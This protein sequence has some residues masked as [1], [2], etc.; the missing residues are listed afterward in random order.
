M[1][2]SPNSADCNQSGI[3]FPFLQGNAEF[4]EKYPIAKNWC[5]IPNKKSEKDDVLLS[6]RAPIGALNIA[7]Q[8]YGIGRG[9]CAVRAEV[10]NYIYYLLAAANNELLSLGTGSTFTAISAEQ[11]GNLPIPETSFAAQTHIA[12]YLDRKTAEIDILIARKERLIEL[13]EE[14]KTAVINQAVTKGLDPDVTMKPSGI[15]W[16]GDIPEHW[17]V[18]RLGHLSKV[19]RGASPRPA[20]SPVYFNGNHTPWITVGEITKDEEKYLFSTSDYLTEAGQ[21]QSRYIEKG[22]LLLSNSGAT[23]GVPKITKIGGC[24]NDGSVAFFNIENNVNIDFIYYFLKSLTLHLRE[25]VKVSGQPNLNTDIVKSIMVSISDDNEQT[26]IVQHIET[27]CSRLDVIIDKFKKQI[28]LL[29]EYRPTLISEVVT[30]KIDVRDE[31][32]Q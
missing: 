27:E 18:K 8:S 9:L 3:G 26:D 20:G 14:E 5:H 12:N 19:V 6:V 2:Q 11:L 17:E 30:G 31:V 25:L 24:I 23:L 10:P 1:G 4:Q 29:K 28:E 21:K 13:Y 22:T 32:V 7:D 16:L 15:D